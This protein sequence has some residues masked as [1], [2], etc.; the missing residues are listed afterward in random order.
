[1]GGEEALEFCGEVRLR[2]LSLVFFAARDWTS[3]EVPTGKGWRPLEGPTNVGP[4]ITLGG[5]G[6]QILLVLADAV[7]FAAEPSAVG[8]VHI[9]P[10]ITPGVA[11]IGI[12]G[13]IGNVIGK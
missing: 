5:L 8:V 11:T 4:P 7:A 9:V 13:I 2:G 3:C 1:M 6:R 10:N 12:I